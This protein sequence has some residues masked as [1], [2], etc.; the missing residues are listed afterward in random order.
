MT[1]EEMLK[2][3]RQVRGTENPC[4]KCQGI[5]IRAY[6][7]T[8]TWHGGMGG[9]IF[10]SDICDKCWGSGD[11][12]KP[13]LDLRALKNREYKLTRDQAFQ[14]FGERFGSG[15]FKRRL[16]QLADLCEVQEKK[17]KIPEGE[18]AFWW[19]NDWRALA[20][21]LRKLSQ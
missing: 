15:L 16:S 14:W 6:S 2:W 5:G 18:H 9:N 12:N 8:A 1:R 19:A 11:E 20:S 13:W 3:F 4:S 21:I 7:S 10:T 17:R